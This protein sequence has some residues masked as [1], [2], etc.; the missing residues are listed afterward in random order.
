VHLAG[1]VSGVDIRYGTS[2][3]R[4]PATPAVAE[5]LAVGRAVLLPGR[6]LVRPDGYVAWADG[7]ATDQD[8]AVAHW[9]GDAPDQH[10][11]EIL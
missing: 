2:G 4:F 11:L 5:C 7:D 1:L 10:I 9:F 8:T 6:V 3:C